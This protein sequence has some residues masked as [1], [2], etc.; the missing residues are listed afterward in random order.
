MGILAC[1]LFHKI[2]ENKIDGCGN[3]QRVLIYRDIYQVFY[4]TS[5][6]IWLKNPEAAPKNPAYESYGLFS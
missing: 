5:S 4:T 2:Q 6:L 3:V 1:C